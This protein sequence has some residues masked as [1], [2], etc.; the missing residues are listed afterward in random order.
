MRD[1]LIIGSGAGGG[2]LALSLSRAGMDVLVLEKG[3]HHRLEDYR[4]D[5]MEVSRHGFFVPPISQDPHMVVTPKT[6]KAV[7]S[8][9]G[10]IA[11]CVG[12]G[13]VHMGGFLYRFHPDDFRMQSRF[14]AYEELADW[15]YDYNELEPWYS[16]AEWEIGVSGQGGA[17][18][19]EGRRSR[20]YPM[21]PLE[22]HPFAQRLESAMRRRGMNPFPTPRSVN[23]IPY[24]NRPACEYRQACAGYGCPVGAKGG[25]DVSMIARAM[26]TGNCELRAECMVQEIL[27]DKQGHATGCVYLDREGNR[28]K[29]EARIVCVCC[30]A[31]ESARLLLLSQSSRFPDGLANNAGQVGKHLQFHAVTMG[32]AGFSHQNHPH[33]NQAS[34]NPFLGLSAMDHY[35]LPEG[36]SDI[37]KGGLLRF[38]MQPRLPLAQAALLMRRQAAP[39]WG[40]ALKNGLRYQMNHEQGV[41]FEFFHDFIPNSRTFVSLDPEATDRWGLPAARISLDLPA[42]HRK[43]GQWLS[44]RAFEVLKDLGAEAMMPTDIGN[45]STYLVHGTCRAGQNPETSVLNSYCQT[46]EV[47]NLFVVDGSFMPTSGGASPTL[48]IAANSF[49]TAAHILDR[50]KADPHF[51]T[52]TK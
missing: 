1:V 22:Q 5:E 31:V 6:R 2:P 51:P 35:F 25:F 50:A 7:P 15:P 19:F 30:S 17:N 9:L 46:H 41:S 28:H 8:Q 24:Q 49:R 43:A 18:P 10:W 44:Q 39:L 45:T 52:G 14:G 47:P 38:D 27:I 12:G 23:S 26:Q 13:T 34:S 33:L 20:E 48:T 16:L 21:P 32:W 3:P 40:Q 29:V 11:V 36:V 42:H 37:A 4:G